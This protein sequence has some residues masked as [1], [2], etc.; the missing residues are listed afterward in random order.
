M[1]NVY[2]YGV[3]T[4]FLVVLFTGLVGLHSLASAR[5][6]DTFIITSDTGGQTITDNQFQSFGGEHACA[7]P[8]SGMQHPH[9]GCRQYSDM[10]KNNIDK[11]KNI[12][13]NDPTCIDQLTI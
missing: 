4:I 2:P 13:D 6:S 11:V 10:Y 7:A 5:R 12:A 8:G 3:T 1:K 9:S